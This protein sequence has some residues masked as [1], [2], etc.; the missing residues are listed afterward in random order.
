MSISSAALRTCGAAN[1]HATPPRA[2]ATISRRRTRARRVRHPG[3]NSGSDMAR[4]RLIIAIDGPSG[5]GKG[6]VARTIADAARRTAHI[7]TGAMYRAVAWLAGHRRHRSPGRSAVAR[8][9]RAAR[10]R[11]QRRGRVDGHDVTAAIRTPEI[12][13]A[14]AIVAR[15]PPVRAVAGRASAR[16]RPRRRRGDGRTRHRIGRVSRRRREDLSGCVARRTRAAARE[17]QAHA[18]GRDGRGV[19]SVAGRARSARYVRPHARRSP[20]TRR[21]DAIYV[22]TT[23]MSRSTTSSASSVLATIRQR[24]P[25]NSQHLRPL[26]SSLRH[27]LS[28]AASRLTRPGRAP[29]DACRARRLRRRPAVPDRPGTECRAR[30]PMSST[31]S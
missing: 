29:S 17:R 15:H 3:N 8:L 16:L 6:T 31:R 5:A 20:L 13:R 19:A 25:Q 22:D 14:A 10:S 1:Q 12:D 2:A 7:D 28:R 23:G 30:L 4:R 18:T 24:Q 11:S 27:F 26:T 21:D 9:A